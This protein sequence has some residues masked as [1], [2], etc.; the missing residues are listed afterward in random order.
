MIYA[1]IGSRK[2]PANA[3]V[4]IEGLANALHLEEGAILR[5]GRAPGADQVFERGAAANDGE[6]EIYLP[7]PKFE[8]HES[9]YLHTLSEPKEEAFI[10]AS[11]FHPGWPYL[12]HP[13]KRLMARN[14]H[15]ILGADLDNPVDFVLCW[16]PGKATT[17]HEKGTGGTGQAM[18]H[19]HSLGIPIHNLGIPAV[20]TTWE[21]WLV[22]GG[23][24]PWTKTSG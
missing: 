17:G 11:E 6:A 23:K 14:A 15:Q 22:S 8:I 19:A 20:Y 9:Y 3:F 12:K 18:R 16:T 13:V 24:N 10:I 5:S 1:G 4:L 7:W 21:K 2:T